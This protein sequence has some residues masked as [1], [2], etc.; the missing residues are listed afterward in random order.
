MDALPSLATRVSDLERLHRDAAAATTARAE[1]A[2]ADAKRTSEALSEVETK[3]ASAL[4]RVDALALSEVET[5]LA[6]T[7]TRVDALEAD[8]ER[9]SELAVAMAGRVRDATR[10]RATR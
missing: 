3:L 7:L 5:K 9:A 1:T 8:G 10:R 2:N 6:S 4:A